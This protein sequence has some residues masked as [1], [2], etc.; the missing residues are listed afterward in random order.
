MKKIF[1]YLVNLKSGTVNHQMNNVFCFLSFHG[2]KIM[3]Y[4]EK[5]YLTGMFNTN[6]TGEGG[7]VRSGWKP[8]PNVPRPNVP[9]GTG[10]HS[11]RAGG[12]FHSSRD[13]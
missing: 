8:R 12:I 6:I 2:A 3:Y 9:F 11:V 1:K 7:I 5:L 4:V 10:G 13:G